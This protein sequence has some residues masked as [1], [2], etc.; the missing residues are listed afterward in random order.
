MPASAPLV[1]V[2]MPVW[3]GERHLA[4]AI[5]SVLAQTWQPLELVIVDDGSED[6][7]R[8][9]VD[10]YAAA[11]ARVRPIFA[12][13]RGLVATLN[14]GCAA[15]RGT[16]LARLDADDIALPDR[17]TQQVAYLERHPDVALAGAAFQ[18]ITVT[19]Q[20]TASVV[21]PPCDNRTIR[22]RLRQA[23]CFCHSAV[24]MRADVFARVGGYRPLCTEAQDYDLWMRMADAHQLA[25][26][27]VV[28]VLY[29]IHARQV[30]LTRVERQAL[31][32][33]AVRASTEARRRG[34]GDP[35]AGLAA[36]DRDVLGGL[37]LTDDEID[38]QIVTAYL[39]CL[40]AMPQLGLGKPA[41]QAL[42][43][44]VTHRALREALE[45]L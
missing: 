24:T 25:N 5:D 38:A 35:L 1:S 44:V 42:R 14:T 20:R 6:D 29:R 28:L 43:E 7:S 30:S 19:G 15:A 26:I 22:Q 17:L 40:S 12:P 37:G 18:Y 36:I 27:P 2:V 21:Y 13:H 34:D 10:R 41:L 11:D 39:N 45:A 3:N 32:A 23:N 16:Y 33:L 4:E 8:A 9:I 31:V